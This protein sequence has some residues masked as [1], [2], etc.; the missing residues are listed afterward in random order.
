M[1]LLENELFIF[2][3]YDIIGRKYLSYLELVEFCGS[4]DLTMVPVAKV[5]TFIYTMDEVIQIG[6]TCKYANGKAGEGYVIRPVGDT[7]ID[8]H[9]SNRLSVKIINNN[10][11]LEHGE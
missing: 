2:N 4:N 9:K 3:V 8:V 7:A 6:T 11:L 5:E 1:G 10:Y